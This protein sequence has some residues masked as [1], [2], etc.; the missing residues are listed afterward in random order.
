ME[1]KGINRRDF[2]KWATV[3]LAGGYFA[4]GAEKSLA[5]MGGGGMGGG[6]MGGGGMGG[7]SSIIDPPPGAP[8]VDP[9]VF[10]NESTEPGIVKVSLEAR[11][12][13]INVNGKMANLLTY[14]GYYPAPTIE[15]KSGDKLR[16][17]FKNSLSMLGTNILGHDRDITNLHTHGLH[18][19]PEGHSDNVMVML[20]SRDTFD[21]EYDLSNQE[22]SSINFY[23][24]HIHGSVAEQYWGGMAGT[25]N[26]ADEI[27]VEQIKALSNFETHILFLKD[28]SLSGSE[29]EAYTSTMD[30]M[31]GKEG[32]TVMVNGLVNP[33]LNIQP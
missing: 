7:G 30:F 4:L 5:G 32:N 10:P 33:V 3:G 11:V 23:H 29:P 16:I 24:P 31:H 1:R 26:V 15:V 12:A 6:G 28:I 19:S 20:M 9:P 22:P 18:V 13:P 8:F 14:N 2:L 17:H 27:S 21:Y 25:L